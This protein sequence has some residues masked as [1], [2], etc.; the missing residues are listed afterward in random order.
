MEPGNLGGV[1]HP[2][3]DQLSCPSHGPLPYDRAPTLGVPKRR[4]QQRH[5]PGRSGVPRSYRCGVPSEAPPNN[6]LRRC[7]SP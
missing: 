3:N 7:N 1:Q 2:I 6:A 5:L 4:I